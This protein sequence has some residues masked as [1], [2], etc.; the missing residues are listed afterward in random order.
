[1]GLVL[2]TPILIAGAM[3]GLVASLSGCAPYDGYGYGYGVAAP[4]Y[5]DS[6]YGGYWPA[7]GGVYYTDGYSYP[8]YVWRG[9]YYPYRHGVYWRGGG[10]YRG[11]R[12][13]HGGYYHG[14]WRGYR[15]GGGHGVYIRR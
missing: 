5:G 1:M 11:G 15:P 3:V 12:Y 10:Y 9:G 13:Y 14:A 4:V 2:R 8:G 6:W 7:Y